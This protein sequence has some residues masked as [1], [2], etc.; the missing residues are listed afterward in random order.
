[1]WITTGY[2]IESLLPDWRCGEIRDQQVIPRFKAGDY[3]AGILAGT[4]E[5][6]TVLLA[7]PAAARG[8][9]NSR[10][11]LAD[12]A[13][14]QALFATG[15]VALAAVVL[16]ALS[17][18]VASRRMYSTTVFAFATAVAGALVAV[19]AYL[20]WRTPRVEQPLG[21]FSGATTAALGAWG[22]NWWRYR[23][24]GPHGCSKCGA[25]LQLLSEQAD[26][27]KLSTVQRLEERI[28]SVDY[29]VWICPACLNQD[30]E[31]YIKRFS[32]FSE[33][34]KCHNRTY[35]EDPQ[36]VVQAATRLQ[37]GLAI[38]DGRCVACKYESSREVT[39]P[40]L[41][42]PTVSS[43]ASRGGFSSGG[44]GGGG[45]RGGGGFGGGSSG[46]GGAGGG[47]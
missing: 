31:A 8:V 33:C 6:A 20:L 11:K 43:G 12:T 4:R 37:T 14:R 34:P 29:D 40:V 16:V 30:T 46:G 10:P 28:G 7:D 27:P 23:R 21:W 5:L 3:P 36:R 15:G 38:V 39:L 42:T 19:A 41:P 47:W 35:K 45:G 25:H 2:G 13:R 9:P 22:L 44:F 32:S 24:F 26:N 1:M 17:F 18:L